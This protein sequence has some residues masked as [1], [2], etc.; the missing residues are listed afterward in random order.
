MTQQ[1]QNTI[2]TIS[3]G[4]VETVAEGLDMLT[5]M[6]GRVLQKGTDYGTI[7][8][9]NKPTLFKPGAATVLAT[10]NCRPQPTL[11]HHEV[12]KKSGFVSIVVTVEAVHVVSGAV[13]C[14]GVGSCT[15]YETKY[16]YRRDE[17]GNRI[18]SPDLLEQYNTY[19]KMAEKRALVDCAMHLP[20][21]ARFFTQDVEDYPIAPGT[22]TDGDE[23]A[24]KGYCPTH[25]VAFEHRTGTSKASGNPY[26]FWSCPKKVGA[27]Y[28]PKR[29]EDY[30]V[31][32]FKAMG[33]DTSGA[34]NALLAAHDT[35]LAAIHEGRTYPEV[36]A[37]ISSLM[38][39]G[40][41]S[42]E[43]GEV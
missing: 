27:S 17:H 4:T 1:P 5:E 31:A 11:T 6:V 34:V 36:I 23:D 16:R 32:E 41:V 8:G 29:P 2:A 20:G 10:F 39:P 14:A 21:V 43:D 19:L 12:D 3:Q 40:E 7:P 15:S 22:I 24:I 26:D 35:T 28:C 37:H 38:E 42:P 9:I 30:L 33:L 25:N 13:M 18:E